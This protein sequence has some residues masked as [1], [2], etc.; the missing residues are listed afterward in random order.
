MQQMIKA[1]SDKF[2]IVY[3]TTNL[4]NGNIYVGVHIAKKLNDGYFGSGKCLYRAI[5]K[6]GKEFFK[7][8]ILFLCKNKE[9][10][11]EIEKIIVNSE[12][13]KKRDNYNS[14]VGGGTGNLK[15][16]SSYK[17]KDGNIYVLFKN[18]LRIKSGELTHIAKGK[19]IVKDKNGN[20]SQVDKNDPR[21]LSG[22]FVSATK[23]KVSV[24]DKNG[25][26]FQIDKNDS[27]YLNGEL[28]HT[29][30]DY[31]ILKNKNGEIKR[32]K[33]NDP[34]YISGEYVNIAKNQLLVKN[35]DGNCFRVEKDDERIKSGELKHF[36]TG[37]KLDDKTKNKIS[38]SLKS[39]DKRIFITKNNINKLIFENE[40][41]NFEKEGWI[42]GRYFPKI[43]IFKDGVQRR[44]EDI[45]LDNFLKEGWKRG[46]IKDMK[47]DKNPAYGRCWINNTLEQKFIKK[48]CIDEYLKVGWKI[49]MLKK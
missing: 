35:K 16:T 40:L 20:T 18:D 14:C 49:G 44:I 10:M 6:Y 30:S 27:R 41:T 48:D 36:R 31:L 33:R 15:G 47:K 34:R 21:Y 23:D 43:L 24:I 4:I 17:D 38:N 37:I 2:Y 8:E 9:T 5:R 32:L 28:K 13:I 19:V 11:Y 46:L 7:R 25:N 26:T 22:E 29:N 42:R 39:I 45:E 3:K 12:F 1:N